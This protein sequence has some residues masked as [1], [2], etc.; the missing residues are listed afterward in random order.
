MS[1]LE[2][3]LGRCTHLNDAGVRCTELYS[4]LLDHV[5]PEEETPC[6]ARE[7]RTHCVHWYDGEP[8]CSCGKDTP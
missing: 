5:Y 2:S 4:H 3:L 8:C 6:L 1:T 7:D